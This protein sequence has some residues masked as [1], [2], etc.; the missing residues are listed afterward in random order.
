MSANRIERISAA[1]CMTLTLLVL[2][3]GAAAAQQANDN[4]DGSS[5]VA[6][7]AKIYGT[8]CGN[9]HNA[10]SPLERSDRQWVTIANH[11]RARANL[12]GKEVRG[13]L[14]FLQATNGD[15]NVEAL[16]G[17]PYAVEVGP[18]SND[19]TVIANGKLLAEQKACVGCHVLGSAGGQVGPSLNGT[20]ER[21]GVDFVRSKL[22][23][24]S[25]DNATS[26]MPNFQLTTEQIEAIVAYLATLQS[27]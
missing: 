12:T 11:M 27:K 15:P 6:D 1:A 5:L 18:V 9:C 14:A 22:Q 16:V 10:R 4:L 8:M 26:M 23:D 17:L 20:I 13:V 25:V 3:P 24:P 19:P 2:S 7:G 21:K